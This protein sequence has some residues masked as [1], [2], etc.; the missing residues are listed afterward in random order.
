MIHML[1]FCNCVTFLKCTSLCFYHQYGGYG[2]Q[3]HIRTEN[4]STYISWTFCGHQKV[5]SLYIQYVDGDNGCI[6][7][8]P[9]SLLQFAEWV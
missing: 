5:F 6:S 2:K 9:Q 1:S 3:F 4:R 8:F 7:V